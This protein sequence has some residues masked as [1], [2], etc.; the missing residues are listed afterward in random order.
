MSP[1]FYGIGIKIV[2]T[3]CQILRLKF[4]KFDIGMRLRPRQRYSGPP[5]EFKGAYF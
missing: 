1:Y 3:M 2:A 4:T 5:A